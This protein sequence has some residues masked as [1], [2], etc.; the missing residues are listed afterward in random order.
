METVEKLTEE[1]NLLLDLSKDVSFDS[2]VMQDAKALIDVKN[3]S[4]VDMGGTPV[5]IEVTEGIGTSDEQLMKIIKAKLATTSRFR[6]NPTANAVYVSMSRI[7]K[8]KTGVTYEEYL[9]KGSKFFYGGVL[10]KY[11][12][13][14]LSNLISTNEF[15]YLRETQ[16]DNMLK[17]TTPDNSVLFQVLLP[18]ENTA[19]ALVYPLNQNTVV[20]FFQDEDLTQ[21]LNLTY[22]FSVNNSDEVFANEYSDMKKKLYDVEKKYY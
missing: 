1:I 22:S 11:T 8:L 19:Y 13:S 12:N 21:S 16:D 17:Y 18:N 3:K 6:S 4:I 20:D 7:F 9:A 5:V 15:F 14:V 10:S 2:T